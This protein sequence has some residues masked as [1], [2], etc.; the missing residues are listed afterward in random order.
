MT[1]QIR[2]SVGLGLLAA[3]AI[4]L[5]PGSAEENGGNWPGFRGAQ[6][7]GVAE[8]HPTAVS[9]SVETGQNI[10]WKTPIP[11]LAH[12]SPIVWGDSVY[13]STAVSAEAGAVLKVG[14]YGDIASVPDEPVHR[15]GPLPHRQEDREGPLGTHRARRRAPAGASPQVHPRE[16]Y[17]GDG[18]RRRSSR[19]SAPR[20]S[21]ATTWTGT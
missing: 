21:T 11:G 7:S 19:S 6:A 8:G 9:W 12:S 2:P 18:R 14:L 10:R 16:P 3:A 20:G 4:L 13:L 15:L 17:A 5:A 1:T